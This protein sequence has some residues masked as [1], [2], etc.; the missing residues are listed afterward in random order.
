MSKI[1]EVCKQDVSSKPRVKDAQGRYLC[2]ECA[3]KLAAKKTAKAGEPGTG[4]RGRPGSAGATGAAIGTLGDDFWKSSMQPGQGATMCPGCS[5]IL[6]G[7]SVLCTR[8]GFDL[9]KGKVLKTQ[10]LKATKEKTPDG[11]G[12]RKGG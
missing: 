1:C 7:G 8:C 4:A 10:I 12:K 9:V 5:N 11:G 6:A 2:K 3:Q